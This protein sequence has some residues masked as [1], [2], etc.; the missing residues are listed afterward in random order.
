MF[1]TLPDE[2]AYPRARTVILRH[3][4]YLGAVPRPT[5]RKEGGPPAG[6][7]DLPA[8]RDLLAQA[9][10]DRAGPVVNLASADFRDG[11][12][13]EYLAFRAQDSS[14]V[15]EYLGDADPS[16][17]LRKDDLSSVLSNTDGIPH[18]LVEIFLTEAVLFIERNDTD[19]HG[20]FFIGAYL[21]RGNL[22]NVNLEDA[23]LWEADLIGAR[24]QNACLRNADLELAL[25]IGADLEKA[26]LAQADLEGAV[27]SQA[28]LSR[29]DLRGANLSMANLQR[30]A[31]QNANLSQAYLINADLRDADLRG[32]NFWGADLSG[33]DLSG[34]GNLTKVQ[35]ED[36]IV[37]GSTQFPSY[38]KEG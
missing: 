9:L 29:A 14:D 37:D 10:I 28:V 35:I 21:R 6:R 33:A 4:A 7:F 23:L 15:H 25:L 13:S 11:V 26:E 2:G 36:A 5:A 3:R 16:K 17:Y 19:L 20:A 34:A 31:L 18:P 30:G 12:F 27:L 24:L 32:A 8:D 38:L 22:N 1:L